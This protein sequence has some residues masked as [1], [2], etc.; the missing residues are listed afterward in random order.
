MF[1]LIK[2]IE[3]FSPKYLGI[4]DLLIGQGKILLIDNNISV[5]W[6]WETK[7]YSG[8]GKFLI[9]GLIDQHVHFIGGGG[10][11]GPTSRA[12]GGNL[13]DFSLAGITTAVGLLGADGVTRTPSDLLAKARAL[14]IEGLTTYMYTGTYQYPCPTLTGDFRSDLVLIDKVLGVG[15]IALADHRGS[16][17]SLELLLKIGSEA[18]IGGLIGGKPGIVHL[19]LGD[20]KDGL[21]L[22]FAAQDKAD[23]P[24]TTFNPT[25]VNRNKKLFCDALDWLAL[26]GWIDLTVGIEPDKMVP[27]ALNIEASI[28]QIIKTKS[29]LERVTVSSDSFGSLP[30]FDSQGTLTG[31]KI[32]K[33]QTLL[34]ELTNLLKNTNIPWEKTIPL[35]TS[36]VAQHL[37]LNEQKG[38]IQTGYDADV[39]VLD[40]DLNIDLVIAKGKPLVEGG[41]PSVKGAFEN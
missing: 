8:S 29:A 7:I 25:H 30:Q 34:K 24:I 11:A 10:E 1:V 17:L 13:S 12:P 22:L 27:D 28:E 5:T 36:N 39:L 33:P 15:E 20:G 2:D 37:K 6:P 41:K 38:S 19:H 9:P 16:Q 14:E 40:K 26:G 4:K 3:I 21:A 18:R 35:F 23:L 32:G 31:I